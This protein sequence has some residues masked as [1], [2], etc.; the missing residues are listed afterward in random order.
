MK[1]KLSSEEMTGYYQE[2]V[3]D[4]PVISIEDGLSEDDWTGWISMN[5][6]IGDRV[7]LV[8]DDLLLPIPGEYPVGYQRKQQMRFSSN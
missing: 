3:N 2:L 1:G 7:Q 4:Y 5:K 8:G 6:A